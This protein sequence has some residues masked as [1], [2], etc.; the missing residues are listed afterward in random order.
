[1][2]T[3]TQSSSGRGWGTMRGEACKYLE[4]TGY[5]SVLEVEDEGR[6]LV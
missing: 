4:Q 5:S 6:W 1:M 2:S 3:S